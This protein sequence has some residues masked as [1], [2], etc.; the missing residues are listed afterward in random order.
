MVELDSEK[1]CAIRGINEGG[2]K[3][4]S[5]EMLASRAPAG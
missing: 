3:F 4:F 1:G 5:G 2:V